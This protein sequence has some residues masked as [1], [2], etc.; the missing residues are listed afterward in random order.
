MKYPAMWIR[1]TAIITPMTKGFGSIDLPPRSEVGER[2][3]IPAEDIGMDTFVR[4]KL[5]G[6]TCMENNKKP[7]PPA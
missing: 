7:A 3:I 5:M 1:R 2:P 4:F 6:I